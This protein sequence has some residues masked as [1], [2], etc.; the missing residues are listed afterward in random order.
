MW[1]VFDWIHH[2]MRHNGEKTNYSSLPK[3]TVNI[4]VDQTIII[5]MYEDIQHLFEALSIAEFT[6]H[7]RAT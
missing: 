4:E 5:Q 3:N 2:S 7:S 6:A 1:D